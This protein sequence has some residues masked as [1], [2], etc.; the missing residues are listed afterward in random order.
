MLKAIGLTAMAI[1]MLTARAASGATVVAS[2]NAEPSV[3]ADNNWSLSDDGGFGF[4]DWQN[5]RS[6]GLRYISTDSRRIDGDRSFAIRASESTGYAMIRPLEASVAAGVLSLAGRFDLNN[7]NGFSGFNLQNSVG[8]YGGSAEFIAVG[9][10]ANFD[11]DLRIL[12][13]G[14]EEVLTFTSSIIGAVIQFSLDFDTVAGTYDLTASANGETRNVSGTLKATGSVA[15]IGFG[16]FNPDAGGAF[17]FDNIEVAA[18]PEPL[19]TLGGS[20]LL[21]L[22]ALRRR[23]GRM[24]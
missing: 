1:G 16:T 15:G 20:A 11:N 12:D 22:I 7:D 19:A 8:S 17:I 24:A 23:V 3:Y 13:G 14:T 21:G 10:R 9:T 4:S 6:N 18:I 2:D 5:P